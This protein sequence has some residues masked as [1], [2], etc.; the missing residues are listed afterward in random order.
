MREFSHTLLPVVELFNGTVVFIEAALSVGIFDVS[1]DLILPLAESG[2]IFQDQVNFGGAAIAKL[3]A[4]IIG[5]RVEYDVAFER[6]LGLHELFGELFEGLHE[7]F[8]SIIL[9]HFPLFWCHLV[10]QWFVNIVNE[11]LHHSHSVF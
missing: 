7:I 8:L 11:G 5:E 4:L 9:A 2:C 3:R 1:I 10:Y 6:L